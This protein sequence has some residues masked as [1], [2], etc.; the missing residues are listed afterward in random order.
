MAQ[1]EISTIV[2]WIKEDGFGTQLQEKCKS[3]NVKVCI[4]RNEFLS[5]GEDVLKK[6]QG[7]I[8]RCELDWHHE[9]AHCNYTSMGGVKLVKEL[10]RLKLGITAPVVFVS[11]FS[12]DEIMEKQHDNMD[13][14]KTPALQHK[15]V[16]IGDGH[17]TSFTKDILGLLKTMRPL[18]PLELSYTQMIYCDISGLLSQVKHNSTQD[19]EYCR[20]QV[21][22]VIERKFPNDQDLIQQAE[23]PNTDLSQLCQVVINKLKKAE[24][25]KENA[26]VDPG[27]VCAPKQEPFSILMIEDNIN[28][29]HIVKFKQYIKK[30]IN[31]YKNE[32]KTY[33]F[34][35]PLFVCDEKSIDKY[36]TKQQFDVVICDIEIR[37]QEGDLVSLGFNILARLCARYTTPIYYIVTNVTRSFYDQIRIQGVNR[38]RLKEEVFGSD[39]EMERFLNNIKEIK[40]HEEQCTSIS[41]NKYIPIFR[42]MDSYLRIPANYP[43]EF[44]KKTEFGIRRFDAFD[45]LENCVRQQSIQLIKELL[46]TANIFTGGNLDALESKFDFLPDS[47][48]VN[49]ICAQMR[50]YVNE[51][52]SLGNEKFVKHFDFSAPITPDIIRKFVIRLILRRYFFYA[53]LFIEHYKLNDIEDYETQKLTIDDIA[54]RVISGQYKGDHYNQDKTDSHFKWVDKDDM[55][56]KCLYYTL[57]YSPELD[58][59]QQMTK[60]ETAFVE[61]VKRLGDAAFNIANE[62]A[63][64]CLDF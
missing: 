32:G 48:A 4:D 59:S 47:Y 62:E 25:D 61:A 34:K 11:V 30:R 56:G 27:F 1:H 18:S 23:D 21:R 29:N 49:N 45:E 53:K 37:D 12:Q 7:F 35:E 40:A 60:E 3:T 13:I 19:P 17:K 38:I 57:L 51:T 6:A 9:S 2:C 58:E 33:L 42:I 28:D 50:N 16:K 10:L 8:V 41:K 63:I 64:E 31:Y 39:K 26:I 52:I 54:C 44:A 55:P 15:F 5:L 14:I 24:S 43:I 46:R 20:A 22:F 36:M